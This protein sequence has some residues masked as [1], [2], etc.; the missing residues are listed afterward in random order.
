MKR[1]LCL[2]IL[3]L[4]NIN[5]YSQTSLDIEV[6]AAYRYMVSNIF[7][8]SIVLKT[9]SLLPYPGQLKKDNKPNI[10]FLYKSLVRNKNI[11]K[12]LNKN[13]CKNLCFYDHFDWSVADKGLINK[14][15]IDT[16]KSI[17]QN[18]DI[19]L[20]GT[21]VIKGVYAPCNFNSRSSNKNIYFEI[22][23]IGEKSHKGGRGYIL[24][25]SKKNNKW[26]LA[27]TITTWQS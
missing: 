15:I 14:K 4:F 8:D 11:C 24:K 6:A 3:L 13:D 2:K 10:I 19:H 26:F 21:L 22:D 20:L 23:C 5:T 27:K 25:L 7:Y 18:P 12:D 17:F 16:S 9:G 1:V